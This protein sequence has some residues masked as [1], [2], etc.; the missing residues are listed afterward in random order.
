M[1]EMFLKSCF[2]LHVEDQIGSLSKAIECKI[3]TMTRPRSTCSSNLKPDMA[4]QLEMLL[5]PGSSCHDIC[6]V[7]AP[8]PLVADSS[9]QVVCRTTYRGRLLTGPHLPPPPPG[10]ELLALVG[11]WGRA[12]QGA[13]FPG[14]R[15]D[16][17]D[18]VIFHFTVRKEHEETR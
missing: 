11:V 4:T 9:P 6:K 5:D 12:A 18:R 16:G 7:C 8:Q 2:F 17:S 14:C 1:R 13:K 10:G 15:D 3:V